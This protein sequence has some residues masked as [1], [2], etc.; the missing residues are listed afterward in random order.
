MD[1]D[2]CR[3]ALRLLALSAGVP[4]GRH[5]QDVLVPAPVLA[6]VPAPQGPRRRVL[7][8]NDV[9]YTQRFLVAAFARHAAAG[10]QVLERGSGNGVAGS[11]TDTAN[12]A[13]LTGT[14]A[15]AGAGG[16]PAPQEAEVDWFTALAPLDMQVP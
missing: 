13:E 3:G 5:A 8:H 15:G 4:A 6:P 11:A 10:W 1:A 12:S 9:P 16:E 14:G 7:V 2:E